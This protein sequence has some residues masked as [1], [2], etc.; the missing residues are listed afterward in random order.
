MAKAH[1]R[2]SRP[3]S[4]DL[5]PFCDPALMRGTLYA[6]ADRLTTRTGALHRAKTSGGHAA[7]VI[8]ELASEALGDR[9]LSTAVEIGC[10]RG[11][12]GLV[13]A[14]RLNPATL[15]LV[16]LSTALLTTARDRL[17][18]SATPTGYVRADFHDIPVRD[19]AC[20][21]VIAAFC[22]Y[23]SPRPDTVVGEIGRC[24][25][26]GGIA[27]LVTKSA[28]SYHE[29]DQLLVASGLDPQAAIRPSL[30]AMAHSG[31][32]EQLARRSL[33][34]QRLQH[35]EHSFRFAEFTHVAEYLATSPKYD[36]PE[37]VHNKPAELATA[38]R[39]ALPEGPVTATSTVT[40]LV[41]TKPSTSGGV[42]R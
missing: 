23:H 20:Q 12:T 35:Q 34:V 26:P 22:L 7:H 29:L 14:D 28:D 18:A 10:G 27:I 16:D 1:E 8:T 36:L 31:N 24:L 33:T 41:A 39:R 25:A 15:T 9:T 3:V 17:G 42:D 5:P 13:V 11:T 40:Y 2:W 21:L 37:R 30:Y 32:I 6:S 4:A 19:H 38:L